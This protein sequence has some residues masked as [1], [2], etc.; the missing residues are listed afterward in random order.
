MT[1]QQQQSDKKDNWN[2]WP[3]WFSHN[4]LTPNCLASYTWISIMLPELSH[5]DQPTQ[6]IPKLYQFRALLRFG[7]KA[8][9]YMLLSFAHPIFAQRAWPHPALARRCD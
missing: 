4:I 9:S 5:F 7:S 1:K 8:L 3:A 2:Q 6:L